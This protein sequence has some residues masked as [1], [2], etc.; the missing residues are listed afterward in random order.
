MRHRLIHR[1]NEV[2]LDIVWRVVAERLAPLIAALEP[3]IGEEG[4]A[5]A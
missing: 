4:A 2:Q 5:D 3:L 1:Y